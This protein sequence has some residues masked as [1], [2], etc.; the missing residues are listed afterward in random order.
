MTSIALPAGL[1]MLFAIFQG[2][3]ACV[4]AEYFTEVGGILVVQSIGYVLYRKT[5]AFE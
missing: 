4:T 5:G 1:F 2:R 3:H